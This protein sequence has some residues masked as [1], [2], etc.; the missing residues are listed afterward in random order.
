MSV[1]AEALAWKTELACPRI[2]YRLP[3][4]VPLDAE[5]LRRVGWEI[6]EARPADAYVPA[7]NHVGLAAVTPTQGFAHWRI[8]PEW[9]DETARRRGG[10]WHNCRLVLR[11]YDVSCIHFNGL[12]AHRIQDEPLPGL[13]GQRFFHLPRPG[14]SQLAEVGFV[15]RSGEFLPA[16]RSHQRAVRSGPPGRPTAIRRPCT[17]TTA[18]A[19]STSATSG[20][21]RTSC[22]SCAGRSCVQPCASPPS[23]SRR[24]ATTKPAP[25]VRE[26]AIHQRTLGHE[27]HVF[28][29]AADPTDEPR[30]VDGVRYHPLPVGERRLAAGGGP[31]VRPRRRGASARCPAV[32]PAASSRMADGRW[33]RRGCVGRASC[34]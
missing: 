19:S 11:I 10:A 17:W 28:L 4:P 20:S 33:R 8:R 15:L 30:E 6:A 16:A 21:R 27:V 13:C 2:E 26:L 7:E 25:F 34:R 24:T 22:A 3:E 12:N 14:T 18:A 5:L 32:R 31:G 9:V 23:R 1:E 29:P